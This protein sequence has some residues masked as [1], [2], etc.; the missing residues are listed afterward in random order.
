MK[1]TI[2]CGRGVVPVKAAPGRADHAAPSHEAIR[3]TVTPPASVKSPAAY[4]LPLKTAS[5]KQ[6]F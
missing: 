2:A 6:V 1:T 3:E 5:V 4:S